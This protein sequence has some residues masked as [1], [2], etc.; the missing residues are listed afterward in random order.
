MILRLRRVFE[1]PGESIG[2]DYDI[3]PESLD[4]LTDKIFC[5]PINI[6]GA[7]V[8]R[9][10]VVLLKAKCRFSMRHECDR[11]LSE[12]EREYV[13]EFE[14]TL[15]LKSYTD[16]DELVVCENAELEL[17]E[18]M[19]GDILLSLP[20]KILCRDDCKGLCL[21]CGKNLNEGDCGCE[22]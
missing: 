13:K 16:D 10:G 20:T 9:A 21:T 3:E 1:C 18:L 8:N 11:C 14:H 6:S 5:S 15:V 19:I 22:K 7:A 12:F 4:Y 17:D 2:F